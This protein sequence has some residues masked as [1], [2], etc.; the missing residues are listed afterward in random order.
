MYLTSELWCGWVG[1]A[2]DREVVSLAFSHDSKYLLAQ[3]SFISWKQC[4]VVPLDPF[5]NHPLLL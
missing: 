2:G 1:Q 3:V 5:H 4:G